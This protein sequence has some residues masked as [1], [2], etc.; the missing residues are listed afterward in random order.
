MNQATGRL[1]VVNAGSN[2][3]QLFDIDPKNPTN[4]SAIGKPVPSG[5]DF[6]QSIAW[7]YAGDKMCVLNG[8]LESNVQYVAPCLASFSA[9]SLFARCFLVDKKGKLTAVGVGAIETYN[10]TSNPPHGPA[11]TASHIIFTA[12]QGGVIV[13][14][15]GIPTDLDN[16]PG[17]MRVWPLSDNGTIA[18][19]PF[20]A[21]I[22]QP[23]GGLTYASPPPFLDTFTLLSM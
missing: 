19:T 10:Q 6:P 4:I 12:D 2:T 3:V 8:G 20:Q 7:N 23:I 14:A 21:N 18:P 17:Y 22:T 15:K 9:F 16:N 1:A 13:V 11:G 5:G